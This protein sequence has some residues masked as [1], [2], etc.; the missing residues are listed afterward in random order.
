MIMENSPVISSVPRSAFFERIDIAMSANY[1]PAYKPALL[2]YYPNENVIS[3]ISFVEKKIT[4]S[5]GTS[6]ILKNFRDLTSFS[7]YMCF[8]IILLPQ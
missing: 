8:K 2:I 1:R 4:Q 5:L 6:P 3:S 7:G